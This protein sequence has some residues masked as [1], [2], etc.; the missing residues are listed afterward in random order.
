M[1]MMMMMMTISIFL[2]MNTTCRN[3]SFNEVTTAMPLCRWSWWSFRKEFSTTAM[4]LRGKEMWRTQ[5]RFST[6]TLKTSLILAAQ[7]LISDWIFSVQSCARRRSS[8]MAGVTF[9]PKKCKLYKGSSLFYEPSVPGTLLYFHQVLGE[10]HFHNLICYISPVNEEGATWRRPLRETWLN[11]PELN[12]DQSHA[13]VIL[14][15]RWSLINHNGDHD[16]K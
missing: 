9:C 5:S 7:F 8:A 13:Q 12:R 6:T 16:C 14:M 10:L 3:W 2:R 4:T 1:M 11:S 15:M